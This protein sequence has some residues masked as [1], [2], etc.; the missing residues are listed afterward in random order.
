MP[1]GGG[2]GAPVPGAADGTARGGVTGD[3]AVLCGRASVPP[4]PRPIGSARFVVAGPAAGRTAAGRTAPLHRGDLHG[5]ALP[6]A[7]LRAASR[8]GRSWVEPGAG[9]PRAVPGPGACRSRP[10][11]CRPHSAHVPTPR[12]RACVRPAHPCWAR[13][14]GPGCR[15]PIRVVRWGEHGPYR[16]PRHLPE[17]VPRRP[18]NPTERRRAGHSRVSARLG[19]VMV[20]RP[21]AGPASR[22]R[23]VR[24][25]RYATALRPEFLA[26]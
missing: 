8:A 21:P 2:R 14:C 13:R 16:P 15:R 22:T 12:R 3:R 1:S 6:V 7:V 19:W 4:M 26:A 23:P 24:P 20:R 17:P 9:R 5:R 18:S 11:G 25:S 10:A